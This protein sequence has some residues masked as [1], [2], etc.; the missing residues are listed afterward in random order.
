MPYS[1]GDVV[2]VVL[3]VNRMISDPTREGLCAV[4]SA[5]SLGCWQSENAVMADYIGYST[6][7]S[8]VK[9]PKYQTVYWKWA[10]IKR[11]DKSVSFFIIC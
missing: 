5:K 9:L 1:D 2:R 10:E 7:Q 6:W 11:D 8:I 3:R 4:G